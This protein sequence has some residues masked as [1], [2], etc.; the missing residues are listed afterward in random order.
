LAVN[1]PLP[2]TGNVGRK[3]DFDIGLISED[4]TT[5]ASLIEG[6]RIKTGPTRIGPIGVDSDLAK[7]LQLND[8]L[9]QL[10][11]QAGRKVEFTLFDSHKGGFKGETILVPTE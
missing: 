10:E 5:Q 7:Q 3:S 1:D 6:A 9:I 8:L 2:K 11:R 4:L